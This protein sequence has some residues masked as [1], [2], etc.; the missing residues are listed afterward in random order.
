MKIKTVRRVISI[1]MSVCLIVVQ[2]VNVFAA[3]DK[4]S[5]EQL[6]VIMDGVNS[7]V[8]QL[9]SLGLN[10]NEISEIFQLSPRESSFYE[11]TAVEVIPYS[12]EF[13]VENTSGEEVVSEIMT[14]SGY[15]GNPPSSNEEQKQRIKKI[16][17]VALNFFKSD[18]YE[19]SSNNG[20]DFGNY[21]KYL[22]L[23]H[24]IDG[25]GR[26]PTSNDLP[27]IVSK[28][29]ISAYNQFLE[30][31]KLSNW[32]NAVAGMGSVLY[33]DFDY[34]TSI[35]AINTVDMTLKQGIDDMMMAGVNG[36]NTKDALATIA[37]LVKS[38]IVENHATVDSDEELTQGTLDYVTTQLEDLDFYVNYDKNITKTI[39]NIMATTTISVIFGSVSI[40]GLCISVVPLYV[41]E[42]TGLIGTAVLVNLQYSFSTRL[43]VRT[44][45]YLEL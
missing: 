11:T 13:A 1:F 8:V 18:Y 43:A 41:Y 2:S 20:T 15:N 36:Y 7:I 34:V 32:A 19:G 37:P 24:Y 35:N 27:Y 31:A 6:E 44:G 22:Y 29:D 25:P 39:I 17:G 30:N 42:V 45:I 5:D 33:S 21:L 28:S 23:S 16:Y 26:V 40:I 9:E 10:D 38:Y 12:G 3:E 14:S 4:V